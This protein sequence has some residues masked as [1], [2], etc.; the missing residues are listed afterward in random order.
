MD[1]V[2]FPYLRLF[3]S[4]ALFHTVCVRERKRER[5]VVSELPPMFIGPQTD[6]KAPHYP[7]KIKT[8]IKST[9]RSSQC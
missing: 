5:E 8:F 7:P 1:Y 4:F 6:V 9:S 2:D 3:V